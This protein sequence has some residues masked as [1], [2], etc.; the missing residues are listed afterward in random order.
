M[1]SSAKG[2]ERITSF[3]TISAFCPSFALAVATADSSIVLDVSEVCR[4]ELKKTAHST[5]FKSSEAAC[6][7]F[8]CGNVC[9]NRKTQRGTYVVSPQ[10]LSPSI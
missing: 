3:G 5:F 8:L 9:N 6:E 1:V 4:K 7:Q 2:T 10:F